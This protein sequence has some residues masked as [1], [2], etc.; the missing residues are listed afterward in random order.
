MKKGNNKIKRQKT[1]RITICVLIFLIFAVFL[2]QRRSSISF[3]EKLTRDIFLMPLGIASNVL[4][5][6]NDELSSN[7]TINL[8][9]NEN[10]EL[11]KEITELKNT[12]NI[13]D[14]LS[15][16]VIVT[17]N[18]VN[19]NIGY[20]FDTI[21][22]NKG[23]NS[24]INDNMAVIASTGLIGKTIH[25]SEYYSDVLLLTNEQ[26]GKISVKINNGNDNF[27]YGLL[28]GY[29]SE[30]NVYYIE[31]ISKTTNVNIGTTV[32]TTGM[33]DIFP[34]GILI[35]KVSNITTDHFDLAKRVEV[36]PAVNI[37]DFTVVSVL[38]RN[39]NN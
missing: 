4:A 9:T 6:T 25:V 32:T 16:H 12:I 13:T 27:V 21:T 11:K 2:L 7:D 3:L 18:V 23:S 8:L 34:S 39:V 15:D 37:N 10:A 5:S 17:S 35:G 33:G 1:K 28:T 36:T 30:N 31:G 29:N 26:M 14:M 38:K 19:R 20:F 24:G 22:I